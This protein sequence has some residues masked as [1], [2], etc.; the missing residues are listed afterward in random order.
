MFRISP[1]R[2]LL[3]RLLRRL[4]PPPPPPRCY[5]ATFRYNDPRWPADPQQPGIQL[6]QRARAAQRH[7]H[8]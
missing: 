7:R 8:P 1:K 5:F 3:T 6:R 4:G 2:G